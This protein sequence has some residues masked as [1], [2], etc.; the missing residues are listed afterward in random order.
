[1][2]RSNRNYLATVIQRLFP[3]YEAEYAYSRFGSQHVTTW[4][5]S[6]YLYHRVIGIGQGSSRASAAECAA[7]RAV[8]Y[9]L[10]PRYSQ[11]CPWAFRR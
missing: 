8:A 5:C 7:H 3:G 11:Q 6:I 2:D 1:M 4:E 10:H 9:H